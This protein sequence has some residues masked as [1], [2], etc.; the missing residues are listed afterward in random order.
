[1]FLCLFKILRGVKNGPL[2]YLASVFEILAGLCNCNWASEIFLNAIDV[3][4]SCQYLQQKQ[5]S[6][7]FRAPVVKIGPQRAAQQQNGLKV[8]HT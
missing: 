5:K 1:M 8:D 6:R 3:I 4:S 7:I 2:Y